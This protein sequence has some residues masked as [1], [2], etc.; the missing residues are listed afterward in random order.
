[1]T[2]EDSR[3]A[4]DDDGRPPGR[5]DTSRPHP[6]RMYDYFL[7]GK[8]HYEAD[9][10]AAERI[11]ANNADA[12]IGAKVNRMFMHRAIRWLAAE[13]GIR[14]FLDVGTGIP[15]EPNLHQVAQEAAPDARVVYTDNDPVVLTHARALLRS[16]PEGR[17]AYLQ[18]DV[19]EPEKIL[20]AP[21]LREV[22]DLGR[23]VALSMIALLHFVPDDL[24][25]QAIVGTLMDALPSGSYLVISHGTADFAPELVRQ[26]IQVYREG[27]MRLQARSR[28]ELAVFFEGMDLVEPGI[29]PSHRWKPDPD[30]PFAGITDAQG[31]GYG[32]VAR[33]R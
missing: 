20:G 15:T 18:A 16:T 31:G 2:A 21:E 10:L 11:V 7:G 29:V 1:M 30:G 32:A 26:A 9:R 6:A 25:A 5:L 33:K 13:A 28:D 27:G 12:A 3:T 19:R 4:T 23:P 24:G 22:L 14:Q 17:T 8:D